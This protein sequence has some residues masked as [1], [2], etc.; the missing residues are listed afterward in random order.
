MQMD[1]IRVLRQT[2]VLP[3][4][5]NP[6]QVL[7][8]VERCIPRVFVLLTCLD[9]LTNQWVL[10]DQIPEGLVMD[11]LKY[12]QLVGSIQLQHTQQVQPDVL[13][14]GRVLID[15]LEVIPNG[16]QH[17]I[18]ILRTIPVIFDV[19]VVHRVVV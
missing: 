11:S 17:P 4:A 15:Q 18:E 14:L 16:N 5:V 9:D 3:D 1:L 7:R 10:Q 2:A 6:L 19:L 13:Q 8:W 12:S